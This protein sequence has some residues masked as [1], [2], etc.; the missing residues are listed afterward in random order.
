MFKYFFLIHSSLQ[1]KQSEHRF[2]TSGH[3]YWSNVRYCFQIPALF[4]SYFEDITGLF[5]VRIEWSHPSAIRYNKKNILF[6]NL[7]TTPT[8]IKISHQKLIKNEHRLLTYP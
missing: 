6:S 5:A 1:N 3:S 2:I 8:N 7:I 4:H